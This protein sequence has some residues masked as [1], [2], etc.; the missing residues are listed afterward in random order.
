ML[1]G[2]PRWGFAPL[3]IFPT[4]YSIRPGEFALLN[5]PPGPIEI[6]LEDRDGR[7]G[8]LRTIVVEGESRVVEVVLE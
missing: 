4:D 2:P 8:T 1:K 7:E 5:L 6:P 3:S